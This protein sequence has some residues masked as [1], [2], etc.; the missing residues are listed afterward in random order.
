[1]EAGLERGAKAKFDL[2]GCLSDSEQA[3]LLLPVENPVDGLDTLSR[4]RDLAACV[5]EYYFVHFYQQHTTPDRCRIFKAESLRFW[6]PKDLPAKFEQT[7]L[8]W[9]MTFKD[10][11]DTDY[12]VGQVWGRLSAYSY[13]LDQLRARIGFTDTLSAFRALAEKWPKATRKLVEDEANSRLSL[14]AL[15]TIFWASFP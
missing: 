8:S 3:P 9:D 2:V 15:N 11:D 4:T 10:G 14:I 13:L 6:L 12:V 7:L 1:M 5:I